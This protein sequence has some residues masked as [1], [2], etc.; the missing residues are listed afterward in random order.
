MA[1]YKKGSK[2]EAIHKDL[3]SL[4]LVGSKTPNGR[5]KK[6]VAQPSQH[7]A[8]PTLTLRQTQIILKS[9]EEQMGKGLILDG[10][11]VDAAEWQELI[12]SL[13]RA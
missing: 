7:Y 4:A 11:P 12:R 13:F 3:K 6:T 5:K 1:R 2:E 8:Y 10:V 9:I